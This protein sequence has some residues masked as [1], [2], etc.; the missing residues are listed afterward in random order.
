M[1]ACT[2]YWRSR[3]VVLADVSMYRDL[4]RVIACGF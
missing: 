1:L 4:A 2:S 3:A